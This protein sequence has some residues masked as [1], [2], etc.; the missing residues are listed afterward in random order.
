MFMLFIKQTFLLLLKSFI[1]NSVIHDI[2][3]WLF[4]VV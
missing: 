1:K 2:M 4:Q 3:I